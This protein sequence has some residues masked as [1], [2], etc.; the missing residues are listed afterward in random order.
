MSVQKRR[1]ASVTTV[2]ILIPAL[3]ES[4]SLPFVL[5]P[6]IKLREEGELKQSKMTL[7]R[8]IVVDN[9]ST[10]ETA[11][12]ARDFGVDVV[13]AQN[14]GYGSACLAGIEAIRSAPPDVVLFLDADGSDDLSDLDSLLSLLSYKT[15]ET[16]S[17]RERLVSTAAYRKHSNHD[18]RSTISMVIGSRAQFA[19]VGT[20]TP[21]QRFGNALSCRLLYFIFGSKFSDLGPF[22]AIRWSALELLEMADKNFGWTVEMQA[23]ACALNLLCAEIDVSYH[24]RRAGESKISGSIRGSFRAGVK[25]LWVI[26]Q[27]WWKR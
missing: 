22:R 11:K 13:W 20:L 6:L 4:E 9:G 23:K 16:L 5:T 2:D 1:V 18:D 3:N 25:I 10:D 7:R 14:R 27:A 12:V 24:P 26:G 15:G 17:K 21:L 8:I 19:K